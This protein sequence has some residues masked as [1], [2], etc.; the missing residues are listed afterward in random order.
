MTPESTNP[1]CVSIGDGVKLTGKID[2]PGTAHIDGHVEGEVFAKELRVGVTGRIAGSVIAAHADI[3]GELEN[4][5][6]VTD[7]LVLRSSSKVRG[8]VT[9]EV[10]EIEQGA[11]IEGS[12][13]RSPD[14]KR[15]KPS[16]TKPMPSL[17]GPAPTE[18]EATPP[19]KPIL[20]ADS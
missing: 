1:G 8:T 16:S 7:T 19:S 17:A 15:A 20:D 10:I 18:F 6:T 9:Y 2:L 14:N 3:H 11:T 13:K 4:D 5:L 12:L